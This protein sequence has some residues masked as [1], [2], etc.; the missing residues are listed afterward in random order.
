M[1]P[2]TQKLAYNITLPNSTSKE[3]VEWFEIMENRGQLEESLV[4]LVYEKIRQE[5]PV[6]MCRSQVNNQTFVEDK[7]PQNIVVQGDFF[8]SLYNWQDSNGAIFKEEKKER[9]KMLSV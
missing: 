5:K 6:E 9:K 4:E 3:V 8:D 7:Q 2:P 1:F